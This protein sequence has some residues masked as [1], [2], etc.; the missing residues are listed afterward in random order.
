M[1]SLSLGCLSK[2]CN[3]R[4][5]YPGYSVNQR[6]ERLEEA[7]C[8]TAGLAMER[9]VSAPGGMAYGKIGTTELQA[10]EFSDRW[11]RPA[12]PTPASWRR[13]AG[14][15]FIDS[16]VFPVDRWQFE[17]FVRIYRQSLQTLDGVCL[18]QTEP[19]WRNYEMKV[20]RRWC[21]QAF[22]I[23]LECLSPFPVLDAIA[24]T[25]W[26]VISPFTKTMQRQVL[27]LPEI[28]K[29]FPWAKKLARRQ[30]HC[31]F[32]RCPLFSYL[33]KSPYSSWSEGLKKLGQELQSMEFDVALVGA[34]A[35]SLPL[36]SLIRQ[37]GRKGIHLGGS[38]QIA[39]GIKG[40]RWDEYW[41]SH[42]NEFW[43]RPSPEETPAGHEKKE[44]GCY[45]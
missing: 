38:T 25:R 34:G 33:E 7:H 27:H 18:W 28:F 30:H 24:E 19:F 11:I 44:K 8:L 5:F 2:A 35:W 23:S 43:V 16:G 1:K 17:E 13:Q 15:L 32:L 39:F 29:N 4:A 6:S 31:Q 10:L 12:W 21:P 14:R 36:L 20:V 40:R 37:M 3:N 9:F 41:G 42:Y 22:R 45:W 26:L